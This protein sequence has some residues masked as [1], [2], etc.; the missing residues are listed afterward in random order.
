MPDKKE[1]E[2]GDYI[3]VKDRIRI[4]YEF[5]AGGRLTTEEVRATREP[6]DKPRIWVKA[7][8]YRSPDDTHPGIGWSWIELP[9][10]TPYTKGSELEN[11]ETSAWGRAIAALGILISGGIASGQ[12]V[13]S[14]AAPEPAKPARNAASNQPPE[15]SRSELDALVAS[16]TAVMRPPQNRATPNPPIPPGV[17]VPT[18]KELHDAID[19]AGID[20]A[21]LTSRLFPDREPGTPLLAAQKVA[22]MAAIERGES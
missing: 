16:Q 18:N 7:A 15:P 19:A 17:M 5:Y 3:E 11:A 14:K 9:G 4:F 21:A 12:E 20:G 22:L 2:L 6:D 10:S 1:F 13:R 8:A